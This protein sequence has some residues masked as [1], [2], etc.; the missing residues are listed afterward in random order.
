MMRPSRH[1][2]LVLVV[3]IAAET[4]CLPALS[5]AE[6]EGSDQLEA[7]VR[8]LESTNAEARYHSVRALGELGD[9]GAVEA[10]SAIVRN[11]PSPEIRGWALLSLDNIGTPEAMAAIRCAQ[12][13]DPD[14]NV[15]VLAGEILASG[16]GQAPASAAATLELN[17]QIANNE[18][19]F[20]SLSGA[21]Q[22]R[23]IRR[24]RNKA[25]A[26]FAL[27]GTG[28]ALITAGYAL[29]FSGDEQNMNSGTVLH[30]LG[31]GAWYVDTILLIVSGVQSH[32]AMGR[33]HNRLAFACGVTM[34]LSLAFTLASFMVGFIT[35]DETAT[36]SLNVV[37]G[38]IATST[39]VMSLVLGR[40]VMRNTRSLVQ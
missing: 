2:E 21:D 13:S 11:D 35:W 32:R 40:Q 33:R 31:V 27:A 14:R 29:M 25:V 39:R 16:D 23:Y 34:S 7:H 30:V 18:R 22:E 24:A 8:N 12:V 26:G 10:L 3:A 37:N 4:L 5:R 15:R 9:E 20:L 19:S 6:T 36:T 17:P 28:L 1:R 38:I